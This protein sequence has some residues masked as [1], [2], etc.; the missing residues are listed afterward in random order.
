MLKNLFLIL[1]ILL[2]F[3]CVEKKQNFLFIL[4]DDLGWTDLGYSGS[5]FHE[6][7]NIDALSKVSIQFTNAYASASICSPTRASIMTGKHPVRVN[8][9]DW[10]PGY[11]PKDQKLSGPQDLDALP[12]EEMTLAE[13]LQD[14]GYKTFFAGKWH[15]GSDGNFPEDQGFEINKGG[16]HAGSPPGGY[17]SPYKNPKLPDGPEGEYL[18]DRLTNE[19]LGFLDTI[20]EDP[21]FLFLAYYTVHT[22]IQPNKQYIEKFETKLTAKANII[23]PYKEE[24]IGITTLEQRNAAY[25]SMLYAL[26]KNIGL[27]IDKLKKEGLYE[28]TTI[29]FTSDNGGL[30][31]LLKNRKGRAPTSVLP[32]RAGKGWLYEGGIRIPLLIKPSHYSDKAKICAEPVV[33]HDFYTTFLS[34]ADIKVDPEMIDGLDISP[35]LYENKSLNRKELFWHYP[36][37]HGSGWTPGAAI[38][39]G[40]WKLIEFYET[41]MVEL[42]NISEDLSE[43]NNLAPKFPDKT[44]SLRNR[45]NELQK[46][47]NAKFAR[48]NQDF[49]LIDI[50]N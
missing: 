32:L 34:L 39:K 19:S 31:T 13:V 5:T 49:S 24:G 14:N 37:Y 1:L 15:L 2:F 38:L 48:E 11:D 16:H 3:S 17:Y 10:I 7:P 45:L 25:A 27:L 46:S 21:F 33:S 40:N 20:D 47:M 41:G 44:D 28:N 26:D 6:T 8:I 29:V 12:L 50:T 35:A 9:T 23:N 4:V 36:H 22:P 30:S 18:T 42:Y 43:T